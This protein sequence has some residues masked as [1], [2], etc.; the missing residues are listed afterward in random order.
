M[1]IDNEFSN[2]SI[3][4]EFSTY[5]NS[6]LN[7]EFFIFEKNIQNFEG[8]S[9]EIDFFFRNFQNNFSNLERAG[10]NFII[11]YF[12]NLFIKEKKSLIKIHLSNFK[13]NIFNFFNFFLN[14]DENY[15]IEFKL[16]FS[17]IFSNFFYFYL[18]FSIENQ[19]EIIEIF[20][21][22]LFNHL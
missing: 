10:Q 8:K 2:H 16:N 22:F 5:S 18:H 3:L 19:K 9:D 15:S 13:F 1:E 6:K 4:N 17:E 14:I 12:K 11:N 20:N 21:D 7:N